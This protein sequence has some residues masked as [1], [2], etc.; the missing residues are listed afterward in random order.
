MSRRSV[1][2]VAV[3]V[4]LGL[5]AFATVRV[6]GGSGRGPDTRAQQPAVMNLIQERQAAE[7]AQVRFAGGQLLGISIASSMEA[8]A[9]KY[10]LS[11]SA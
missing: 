3:A 8:M 5:T 9:P 1:G 7:K 2:T 10:G 4:L 11:M 6:L